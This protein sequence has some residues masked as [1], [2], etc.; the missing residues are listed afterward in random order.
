[1]HA[2]FRFPTNILGLGQVAAKQILALSGR[3]AVPLIARGL[4]TPI[5]FSASPTPD[6]E[7]DTL[8]EKAHRLGQNADWPTQE[9]YRTMLRRVGVVASGASASTQADESFGQK[10]RRAIEHRTAPRRDAAKRE[11][12]RLEKQRR[13]RLPPPRRK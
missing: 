5:K 13:R 11:K 6:P 12:E 3:E 4:A 9:P 7:L 10:L 8:K 1:M 2:K